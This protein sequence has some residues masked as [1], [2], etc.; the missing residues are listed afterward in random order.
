LTYD[1]ILKAALNSYMVFQPQRQVVHWFG[2]CFQERVFTLLL[3]L[4]R[5]KVEANKDVRTLLA[6]YLS[7]VEYIFVKSRVAPTYL[8]SARW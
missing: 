7:N 4:N 6:K 5:L 3:V 1:P 8:A 2:P